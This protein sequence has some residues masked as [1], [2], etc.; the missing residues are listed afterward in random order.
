MK[1]N[2]LWPAFAG[3]AA[4]AAIA[5]P[6]APIGGTVKAVPDAQTVVVATADGATLTVR[7]A[8]VEA[9]LPCQPWGPDARAAL[10]EWVGGREVTLR[11]AGPAVKGVLRATLWRDG[12][13]INRH[14]VE[15]GHAW[16]TR[17]RNGHGPYLK[18]ERM[19]HALSRGL[20]ADP[21]A[22]PPAQFRLQHGPCAK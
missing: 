8:D 1:S 11:A 6:H 2:L 17:G 4:A 14:L 22:V 12:L 7:L 20:H 3:F 10:Q 18:Q 9:P 5:A 15:E 16:S 19:A 13:D 21:A